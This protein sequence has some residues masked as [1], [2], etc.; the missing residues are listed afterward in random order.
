MVE[1][2]NNANVQEDEI[3]LMDIWNKIWENKFLIIIIVAVI[4]GLGV[5]TLF[6]SNKSSIYV[7]TSF[8]YDFISLDKNE[9]LDGTF[10]NY[11]KLLDPIFLEQVKQTDPEFADLNVEKLVNDNNTVIKLN[12]TKDKEGILTDRYYTLQLPIKYFNNDTRLSH[13]FINAIHNHFLE[14]AKASNRELG[15][16]NYFNPNP[17]I[18]FDERNDI[19]DLTFDELINIVKNQHTLIDKG[20]K[21]L[22]GEALQEEDQQ[23]N[24]PKY[25]G[26]HREYIFWYQFTMQISNLETEI[27]EKSYFNNL[28]KTKTNA[29]YRITV[30]EKDI[31]INNLILGELERQ[32][33]ELVGSGSIISGSNTLL[34]EIALRT[35][36]KVL[37]ENELEQL[38]KI[39]NLANNAVSNEEFTL[40]FFKLTE[41]LSEHVDQFNALYHEKLDMNTRHT[42]KSDKEF[43]TESRYNIKVLAVV[44]AMISAVGAIS[45]ALIKESILDKKSQSD[46]L[47]LHN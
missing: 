30:L 44:I 31:E 36:N 19:K 5:V 12:E 34:D 26:I 35:K 29:K 1:D 37:Y 27:K 2:K 40:N 17:S 6:F 11:R 45:V 10:F 28:E 16:Y 13:S 18:E 14:Y 20:Y 4:T 32:Y 41:K 21:N 15:I 22:I 9:F 24:V 46:T 33:K 25:D 42:I 43:T 39:I 23:S 38:N 3:S 7:E 8:S 47:K